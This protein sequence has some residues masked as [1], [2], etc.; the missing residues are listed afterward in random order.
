MKSY[1]VFMISSLIMIGCRWILMGGEEFADVFAWLATLASISGVD[2]E[3]AAC[4][5]YGAGCPRCG[6]KPCRCPVDPSS[7]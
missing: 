5:K 1:K 4:A 2:L 3:A 6:G 7:A